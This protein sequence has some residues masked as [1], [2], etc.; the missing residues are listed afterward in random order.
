MIEKAVTR[1]SAFLILLFFS[2]LFFAP[3]TKAQPVLPDMIGATQD[4]M[5]VLTW[6]C[7]YDGIKSI[8][9]Q[10]SRDSVFNFV[11]IGYVKDLAKGPQAFIDG[12]PQPGANWYRLY[13]VFNSNLTWY[14]N[15]LKLEVDSMELL[16]QKVLPPNDSLQVFASKVK[17]VEVS[18]DKS[19]EGAS[20]G[21]SDKPSDTPRGKSVGKTKGKA[22]GGT[23]VVGNTSEKPLPPP[24]E[25]K[26][27]GKRPPAP[28]AKK[29][30]VI[31]IPDIS[32]EA[33]AVAYIKSRY[34]FTNPFTGHVNIEIPDAPK[35][36]YSIVFFNRDN[37][38]VLEIPRIREPSVVVDKRNFQ[39]KGLY[40]FELSKDK[41]K[42]ETGFITIY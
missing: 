3:A 14:S 6:T 22:N 4:G 41:A 2:C 5:N 9:V 20:E 25:E 38:P 35:Y 10:R 27:P 39:R 26:T 15:Y 31:K 33:D 29:L 8:A 1:P 34:V 32:S 21:L 13:I 12:H 17:M 7:Q 40:K 16:K 30:P 11:T 19:T 28:P 42:L 36:Q 18:A 37:Q 24:V 23:L